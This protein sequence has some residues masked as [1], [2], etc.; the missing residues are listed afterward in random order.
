[1]PDR[2]IISPLKIADGSHE[3]LFQNAHEYELMMDLAFG[4]AVYNQVL[5]N[6]HIA[7]ELLLKALHS[8][9]TGRVHPKGHDIS[10][11][12]L[13]RPLELNAVFEEIESGDLKISVQL[14]SSAWRMQY[15]YIKRATDETD[16]EDY[17]NAYRDTIKWIKKKYEN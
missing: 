6:G 2:N 11:L 12:I 5:H 17:L 16:A 1:M 7:V 3:V 14:I 9:I 4:N 15:R 13:E 10:K 8:K